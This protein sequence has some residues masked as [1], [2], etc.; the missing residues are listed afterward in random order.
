MTRKK[1]W[2]IKKRPQNQADA[3]KNGELARPWTCVNN[4]NRS[5]F[6]QSL[7]NELMK[8]LP[9]VNDRIIERILS[10]LP[11]Y[12][13]HDRYV[14]LNNNQLLILTK[15]KT[16][17]ESGEMINRLRSVSRQWQ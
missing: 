2:I 1:K 15:D 12:L 16:R 10:G 17:H 9:R 13:T 8:I 11:V 5:D 6:E 7:K 14:T 4:C 3:T